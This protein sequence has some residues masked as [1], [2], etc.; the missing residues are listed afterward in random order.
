M[1]YLD[2]PTGVIPTVRELDVETLAR[3]AAETEIEG[4]VAKD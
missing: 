4:F 2:A 1:Q 3:L